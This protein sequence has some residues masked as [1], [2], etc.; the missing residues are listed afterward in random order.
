MLNRMKKLMLVLVSAVIF[1]FIGNHVLTAQAGTATPYQL[2]ITTDRATGTCNYQVSG[3]DSSQTTNMKLLVTYQ[4]ASGTTVTNYEQQIVGDA[5]NIVGGVYTGSFTLEQMT[6]K[7]YTVYTVSV[8]IGA[9]TIVANTTCDFSMQISGCSLKVEGAKNTATRKVTGVVATSATQNMAPVSNTQIALYVWKKGQAEN[10]AVTVGKAEAFAIKEYQWNLDIASV[11]KGNG[12][13]YAKMVMVQDNV[14]TTLAKSSFAVEATVKSFVTK[15]NNALEENKSFAV[16]L[17]GLTNPVEVRKVSFHVCNSKGEEVFVKNAT[18]KNKDGSVY[19]AEIGLKALDY[20]LDQYT[21]KAYITDISGASYF[22]SKT[23][24]VDERASSKAFTIKK[25]A[26]KRSSTYTI[27]NVYVPGKVKK[28]SF[29]VYYKKNGKFVLVDKVNADKV[30]GTKNYK[31]TQQNKNAGVYKIYAYAYTNWGTEELLQTQTMKVLKSEAQKNGWF[32]EKYNGKTYK[33]Y[34]LNGE[35]QTDLTKVLGLK[36]SST[37]NVNNFYIE[38][39]RAAC[40]VTVYAYDSVKKKYIIP[41]KTF[42]VSVGRDTWTSAGPGALNENTSFSPIG[43]FSICTNG[44]SPK[45]SVKEM[46]EP[47]GSVC[48][49][50]WASHIVGNVYFHAVAVGSNSHYALS[51]TN[52]NRLGT[53]ASAGCIR[54]TVADAKWIYDYASVGST[55]KIVTGDSSHPGPLGKAKTITISSSINYDPTDP[56]V[57]L[58]RKKQ[59]YASKR[60]SGYMTSDGKKVGY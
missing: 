4:D 13:Y 31:A 58:S 59:D 41:V 20:K 54:M 2:T 14:A 57:P 24:T 7:V 38:I 23:A 45:Y 28:V 47:D 53:A 11:C 12:T 60:I 29:W 10:T 40:C 3:L 30:K 18:D 8:V 55:V 15:K 34:Y 1:M 22:I 25:S 42:T 6:H 50:R 9:D 27:K 5:S 43:T 39:N 37:S 33:F 48:Y 49:A 44:V 36:Y 35:K 17:Q 32:Y 21:V 16:S 19:Y 46:H 56:E 51:A 26:K 52:Y